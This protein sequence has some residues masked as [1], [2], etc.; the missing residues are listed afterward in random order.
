MNQ[1]EILQRV[2]EEFRSTLSYMAYE[3]GHSAG[4]VE[5]EGILKGLISDLLPAIQAFEKR[6]TNPTE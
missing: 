2:P 6:L 4:A 5:V 3:R 1:S